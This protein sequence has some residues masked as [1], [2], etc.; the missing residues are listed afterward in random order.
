MANFG[1]MPL[2]KL[3]KTII[4]KWYHL[5]WYGQKYQFSTN[6]LAYLIGHNNPINGFRPAATHSSRR[7]CFLRVYASW[8]HQSM[9]WPSQ[10]SLWILIRCTTSMS[11]RSSYSSLWN[12]MRKSSPIR[13]KSKILLRTFL[14]NT[15]KAAASVLNSVKFSTNAFNKQKKNDCNLINFS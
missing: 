11:L 14:S 5:G 3:F 7:L 8:L 6:L 10:C 9:T 12:R 4:S 15:L 2:N 1:D 13:T